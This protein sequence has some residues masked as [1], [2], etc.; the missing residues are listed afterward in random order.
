MILYIEN[1]EDA[2]RKLLELINEFI[3]VSGYKNNTQKFL[4]FLYTNNRRLETI[5]LTIASKRIKYLGI[6]LPK[7]ARD[8]N[9]ENYKMLM[10]EIED[11]TNRCKDIPCS[12]AGRVNIVKMTI[13]LKAFYRFSE[14]PVKL[15]ITNGIFSQN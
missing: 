8:L 15:Q 13:L 14:I 6:N 9:C 1:P 11:D 3:K 7:V 4:A 5:P 12:S 10:R 2:T